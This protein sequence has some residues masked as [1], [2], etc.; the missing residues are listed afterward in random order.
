MHPGG[1]GSY[2][3]GKFEAA[4]DNVLCAVTIRV[5]LEKTFHEL[6]ISARSSE[7]TVTGMFLRIRILFAA[8]TFMRKKG[9]NQQKHI[10]SFWIFPE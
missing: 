4:H 3:T 1:A 10:D 6:F 9:A 2:I 8:W 7:I 5:L